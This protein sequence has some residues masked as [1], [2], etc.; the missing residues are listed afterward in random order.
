MKGKNL[1]DLNRRWTQKD[2]ELWV[3]GPWRVEYEQLSGD[4]VIWWWPENDLMDWK[5]LGRRPT[6]KEGKSLA[7][8]YEMTKPEKYGRSR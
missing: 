5:V 4:W 3:R 2:T 6:A 1:R 7:D 8:L